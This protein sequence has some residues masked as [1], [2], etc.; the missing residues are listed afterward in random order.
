MTL[1]GWP[2][3]TEEYEFIKSLT[4][5][6]FAD[7]PLA[8]KGHVVMVWGETEDPYDALADTDSDKEPRI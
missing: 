1:L 3:E 6:P 8:I 4:D 7:A 5:D 2:D